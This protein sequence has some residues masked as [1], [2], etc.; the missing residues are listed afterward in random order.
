[1][2]TM[3]RAKNSPGNNG[4]VTVQKVD[5]IDF[6]YNLVPNPRP[7]TTTGGGAAADAAATVI[8]AA[9]RK[10][11]PAASRLP[12][13][14]AFTKEFINDYIAQKKRQFIQGDD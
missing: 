6:V 9:G 5:K 3:F 7:T 8:P 10:Q 11:R 4:E 12:P 1:M 13:G 2:N 14:G